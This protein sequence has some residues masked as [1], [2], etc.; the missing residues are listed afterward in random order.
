VRYPLSLPGV[1]VA[2]TGIGRIQR[3]KPEADQLVANLTAAVKDMPSL[4]GRLRIEK[5]AAALHAADTK[6]FQEKTNALVQPSGVRAIQDGDRVR[7]EWNTAFAGRDPIR[8]YQLMAGSRVLLTIP[9]RPQLTEAP[10]SA[11]VPATEV[12]GEDIKVVATV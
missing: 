10:L 8:A 6:Y 5:D 9:F 2:I 1:T 3:D 7:V 12:R 4:A 11:A